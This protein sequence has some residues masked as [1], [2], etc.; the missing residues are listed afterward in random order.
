MTRILGRVLCRLGF[1]DWSSD[2][3]P[4]ETELCVRCG[5]KWWDE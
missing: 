5:R 3:R 2:L 1:H 4:R